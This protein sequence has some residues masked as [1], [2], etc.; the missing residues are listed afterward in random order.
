MLIVFPLHVNNCYLPPPPSPSSLADL[1]G[2]D[3]HPGRAPTAPSAN[4]GSVNPSTAPLCLLRDPAG[5]AV[6]RQSLQV[7]HRPA[8]QIAPGGSR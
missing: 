4:S 3:I 6:R 2:P 8:G 7:V 1:A 5:H